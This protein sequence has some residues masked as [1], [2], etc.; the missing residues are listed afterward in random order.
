MYFGYVK[1]LV[2]FVTFAGQFLDDDMFLLLQ[3]VVVSTVVS[4]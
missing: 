1:L 4:Q 3:S 2:V